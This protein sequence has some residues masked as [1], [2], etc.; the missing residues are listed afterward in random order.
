MSTGATTDR[1]HLLSV[2]CALDCGYSTAPSEVLRYPRRPTFT[3]VATTTFV[4]AHGPLDIG[5]M[6]DVVPTDGGGPWG[7][8]GHARP[9]SPLP[10]APLP[11]PLGELRKLDRQ[12]R[13]R[14]SYATS[15]GYPWL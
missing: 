13:K 5:L 9:T 7:V 2:Q 14:A 3:Q 12:S 15:S 4:T 6:P 8:G 1:F 11:G 10:S